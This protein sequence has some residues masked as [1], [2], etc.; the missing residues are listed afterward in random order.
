M[1]QKIIIIGF[2]IL[3][4]LI[5]NYC[6]KQS[7]FAVLKGPYLGQ[8]PPGDVPELF[9]PGIVADIFAEHS[10]AAFTPDGKEVFWT[11]IINQGQSPRLTVTMHMK[12]VEGL[13]TQ[14]ELAPFNMG[15]VTS[16]DDISPNG[17]RLYFHSVRPDEKGGEPTDRSRTW[18]VD[19]INNGWGEPRL[20]NFAAKWGMINRLTQETASGNIY[21][22]S[23]LPKDS[24]PNPSWGVGFFRSRLLDGEYQNPDTLGPTIN[25]KH[26]DYAFHV[27]PNEEF[28]IFAS[29]RPGG[30]TK[31]DLYISYHKAD[32]SWSSAINLGPKINSVSPSGS[33]W[34]YLSPD[35]KYLF[36]TSALE[37]YNDFDE[38]KYSFAELKEI[39]LSNKNGFNKI[40]WINTSF[41]EKL[42]PDELK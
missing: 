22:E 21:F 8:K 30:F 25:S 37:P 14:P 4:V 23:R 34:P 33:D 16:I 29:D 6:T 18:I 3:L 17:K 36:F 38:K 28:I 5:F 41:I 2:V 15:F 19:K 31:L 40:Y 32:D 7:D 13:W 39:Y 20:F 1:K 35:G 42:K 27:D 26:L 11:R 10:A 9:A 24:L 12:Q